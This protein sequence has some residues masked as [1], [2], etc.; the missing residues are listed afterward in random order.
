ML[1]KNY[2]VYAYLTDLFLV[3]EIKLQNYEST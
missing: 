3:N 1:G 2:V